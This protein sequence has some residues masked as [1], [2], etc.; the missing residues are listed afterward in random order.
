MRNCGV[1]KNVVCGYSWSAGTRFY[2]TQNSNHVDQNINLNKHKLSLLVNDII[3]E[4]N[5]SQEKRKLS[6]NYSRWRCRHNE[7][8]LPRIALQAWKAGLQVIVS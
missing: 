6:R 2:H 4:C 1:S 5:V 8:T 7:T 3:V